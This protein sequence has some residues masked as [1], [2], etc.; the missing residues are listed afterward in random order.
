MRGVLLT[1]KHA[2]P[3]VAASDGC[4]IVNIASTGSF[5]AQ[6]GFLTHYASKGAVVI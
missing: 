1:M 4:S 6:P 3:A 2:I 5:V